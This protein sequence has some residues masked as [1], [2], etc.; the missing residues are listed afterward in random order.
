MKKI[1]AL[2]LALVLAL[3]LCGCA[4]GT[5]TYTLQDVRVTLGGQLM[6]G[7]A[8]VPNGKLTIVGGTD[9]TLE[10]SGGTYRGTVSGSTVYWSNAPEIV[11]G[12][13]LT[14]TSLLSS[15]S[16]VELHYYFYYSSLSGTVTQYF[17]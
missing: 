3:A 7:P 5:K 11:S 15:G 4:G 14:D 9:L 13:V 1:I 10:Y 2:T 12:G 17:R 6:N 8:G 16:G